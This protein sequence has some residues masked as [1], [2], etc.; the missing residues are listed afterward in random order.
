MRPL[1]AILSHPRIERNAAPQKPVLLVANH[2]S[3]YDVPLI[4]YALD[5][6]TRHRVAVAMAG[7]KLLDFRKARRLGNFFLDLCGPAAYFLMRAMFNVF[8]LPQTV[9]F[10]KSF[11]Y[12]GQGMDHGF[13]VLV[14]PEGRRTPDGAMHS[15]Q[16]GA[17]ML[18]KELQCDVIPLYLGGMTSMRTASVRVGTKIT[19]DPKWDAAAATRILEEAVFHLAKSSNL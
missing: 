2:V 1:V 18:W 10:R 3:V 19:L 4:L 14:F 13:H 7:E 15:F 6:K 11:A 9:N 5:W 16:K 8:P 17:G 12:A